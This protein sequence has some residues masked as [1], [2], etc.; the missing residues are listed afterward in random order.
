M[1]AFKRLFFIAVLG[2]S[3]SLHAADTFVSHYESLHG[4]SVRSADQSVADA[5]RKQQQV[6]P[7]ELSFEAF[8]RRFDLDLEPNDRVLDA[9]PQEAAYAG[10]AAYRGHLAGNSES[11]ARIVMFDGMPR[12]IVWDGATMYAIEAPGDSS[13]DTVEPVI[14]RLADLNIVPGTMTCD[15]HAVSGNAATVYASMKGE[16]SAPVAQAAGA[17]S[18][19]T[20][21]VMSDARF[22]ASQGGSTGAAAAITARFNNVDGWFSEQ[23]GVQL[24]VQ[25]IETFDDTSDPFDATLVPNELLDQL[26]EYRLQ[27]PEHRAYGLTHLYTGRDFEGTTVGIAWR[28]ALCDNY[29]SAGLSQGSNRLTTDSL[30]AAHEIGHN[31]NAEHD[32]DPTGSCPSEPE[33]YIMAPRVNGSEQYSACSIEVMQ[34]EAATARCV[35]ALP[36]IDVGIEQA[37]QASTVLLGANTV[38][39][40]EVSINGTVEVADV[41]ADFTL[42]DVLAL[43][44]IATS[45]GNC[46]SGAGSVSCALGTLAGL[47]SHTITITATPVAVGA[48]TLSAEVT[49]TDTDERA[50]NDRSDLRLTVDPAVDL[51]VNAPGTAPT[52]VDTSTTVTVRLEN[53]SPLP[54]SNVVLS[55]TLG[56]GLQVTAASWP[57]GS[58]SVAARQIDCQASSF[59]AQSSATLSITATAVA[60]GSQSVTVNISSAEADANPGDNSAS[61]AVNVVTPG[62]DADEGGGGAVNAFWLLLMALAT[63]LAPRRRRA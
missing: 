33:T 25:L 40:Y 36:A 7:I 15:A 49:T 1:T 59:A 34:E 18:E 13:V 56:N 35:A 63:V 11:W 47:S 38:I 3:P 24:N 12:G 55:A 30:I 10:V 26:S 28:G 44:S 46:S 54:A 29:F 8:G 2:C 32:G 60:T 4:M 21:S 39:D 57:L 62:G 27:T 22:T 53:L 14:F 17:V 5:S 20:V 19:I 51:V 6:V 61:G 23:V 48:G 9:L 52:F 43:D 50:T 45:T 16:W 37:D 41:V 58:C 42:P 31:F